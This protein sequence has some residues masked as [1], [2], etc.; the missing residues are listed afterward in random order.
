V[1]FDPETEVNWAQALDPDLPCMSW[2][3]VSLYGTPLWDGM[4]DQQRLDLARHEVASLAGAGIWLE[5]VLMRMLLRHINTRDPRSAHVRYAFTEIADECRHSI[6]FGR[7]ITALDCPIYRPGRL[8]QALSSMLATTANGVEIFAGAL[9]GEEILDQLQRRAISDDNVQPLVRSVDR[10][11]V[12]E[13][14]RH[15]SYARDELA[16][17]W[18]AMSAPRRA[19]TRISV[20]Q[21]VHVVTSAFIHPNVYAAVGLNPRDARRQ[22]ARSPHRR[23]TLTHAARNLTRRLQDMGLIDR[24]TRRTW[25][26]AGLLDG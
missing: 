11:H 3:S 1:S 4:S 18:Q 20:A 23:Q 21:T 25:Y 6:M 15:I 10:I 22:V 8:A 24:T 17:Q 19:L 26:R 5:T 16:R 12:V 13:E 9:I 2:E 14:A 7:L